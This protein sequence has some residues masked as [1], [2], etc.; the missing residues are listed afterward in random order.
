MKQWSFQQPKREIPYINTFHYKKCC[1]GKMLHVFKVHI[2]LRY[3]HIRFSHK[4]FHITNHDA[5]QGFTP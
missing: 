2:K 4:I 3:I 5:L 1:Y